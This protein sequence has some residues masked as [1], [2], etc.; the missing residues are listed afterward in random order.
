MFYL[1]ILYNLHAIILEC[2]LIF[3][4]KIKPGNK[5][6][7]HCILL[8]YC[9]NIEYYNVL[10]RVGPVGGLKGITYCISSVQ[11]KVILYQMMPI[12]DINQNLLYHDL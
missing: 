10:R 9:L 1:S 2:F 11:T 7:H 4:S 5:N 12:P 6:D 3:E 8:V